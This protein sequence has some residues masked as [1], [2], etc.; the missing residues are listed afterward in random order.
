MKYDKIQLVMKDLNDN[1]P[2]IPEA[3]LDVIENTLI[4]WSC[5]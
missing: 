4:R 1:H 5:E 2:E 3:T